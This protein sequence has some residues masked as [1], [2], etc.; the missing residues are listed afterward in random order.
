MSEKKPAKTDRHDRIAIAAYYIAE[1]RGFAPGGEVEDW[2]EAERQVDGEP[3]AEA[4]PPVY[5]PSNLNVREE[6][7]GRDRPSPLDA[8]L[9]DEPDEPAAGKR[10]RTTEKDTDRAAASRTRLGPLKLAGRA[11]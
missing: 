3:V 9:P 10:G 5:R 2:L 1:R 6:I 4:P 7:R 11:A 8:G